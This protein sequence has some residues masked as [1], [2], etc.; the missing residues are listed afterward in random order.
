MT[1][2]LGGQTL[3]QRLAAMIEG[4]PEQSEEPQA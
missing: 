3:S 2:A 4:D 1:M